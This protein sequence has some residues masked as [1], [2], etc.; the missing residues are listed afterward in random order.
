MSN[1]VTIVI[2]YYNIDYFRSTLESLANQTNN[3][4]QVFIGDDNSPNSP[5]EIINDYKNKLNIKYIKF[6]DN[7]GGKDLVQQ[8]KRCLS[9]VKT[10]WFMI[11]GDDDYLSTNVVEEFY[12]EVSIYPNLSVFRLSRQRIDGDGMLKGEV[13]TYIDF[14]NSSIFFEKKAK[15]E[16]LSSLGEFI[17]SR[18]SFIKYGIKSYP[19]AFY[20]DNLMVLEYS[21]FSQIKNIAKAIAY[22]RI[23]ENS[24]S[25]NSKNIRASNYAASLFYYDLITIYR[26]YFT[27]EQVNVFFYHIIR[28]FLLRESSLGVSKVISVALKDNNISF[29]SKYIFVKVKNKIK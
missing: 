14:E 12:K 8:W 24:F 2:A 26:E 17:F 29:F 23:S 21:N 18:E 15:G 25:G 3:N 13:N 9:Y 27:R 10:D 20:S 5:M 1:Q 11:L 4:F 19:K 28:H 6:E 7:I 16:V 22:I